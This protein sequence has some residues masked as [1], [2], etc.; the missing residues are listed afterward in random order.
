MIRRYRDITIKVIEN[1]NINNRKLADYF[2]RKYSEK[3]TKEKS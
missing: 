1:K 3:I 2:A